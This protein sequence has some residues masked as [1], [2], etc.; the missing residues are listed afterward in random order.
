MFSLRVVVDI[1]LVAIPYSNFYETKTTDSTMNSKLIE[2][3]KILHATFVECVLYIKNP[4]HNRILIR[5]TNAA[6]HDCTAHCFS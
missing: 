1:Q 5:V 6:N 4:N 3:N 2:A